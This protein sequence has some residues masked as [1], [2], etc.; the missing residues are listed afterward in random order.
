MERD[1]LD[2]INPEAKSIQTGMVEPALAACAAESRYQFERHG[3]FIADQYD[4]SAV[5]PVFN[6][7]VTLRDSWTA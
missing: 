7:T 5:K 6:R 4:H 3:Y 1:F 2:D